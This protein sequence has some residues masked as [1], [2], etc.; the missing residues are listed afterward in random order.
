MKI[1]TKIQFASLE[2]F[3]SLKRLNI[4]HNPL[5]TIRSTTESE[6]TLKLKE[7]LDILVLDVNSGN[8]HN[9]MVEVSGRC[10]CRLHHNVL[11]FY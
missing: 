10:S 8:V 4:S 2:S 9:K 5:V 11:F 7:R 6:N 3:P 1:L